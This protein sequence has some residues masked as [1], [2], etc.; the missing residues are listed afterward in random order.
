M[1]IFDIFNEFNDPALVELR[2]PSE[3]EYGVDDCSHENTIIESGAILC[4]NCGVELNKIISYEKDWRYYGGDDCRGVSDP[5]RCYIRKN[6]EK[7]IFKD[8]ESLGF[9]DKII[10]L[11]NDIYSQVT[12]GKIYRGNSRKSLVFSSIFHA[13]KLGGKPYSCETLREIFK[14]DRKIVLKG[15][16]HV[17]LSAPKASQIRTKYITPVE[18]IYE[19]ASKFDISKEE[20]DEIVGL[21]EQIKN[22]SSIIN[23]S[24]PQSVAS[25]MI[26]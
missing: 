7:N 12:K 11:A 2:D 22:K 16:K 1:S 26:Y 20:K 6:E 14:L 23:R 24:R 21:Y 4:D 5:N 13:T 9:S 19:Y 8:V 10:N 25:S 17:N 3:Q 18:L 15:L